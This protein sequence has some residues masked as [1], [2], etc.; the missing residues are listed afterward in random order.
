MNNINKV[1]TKN[2]MISKQQ[3]VSATDNLKKLADVFFAKKELTAIDEIENARNV[4][5]DISQ[6]IKNKISNLQSSPAPVKEKKVVETP[7]EIE[8]KTKP[9][10]EPRKPLVLPSKGIET[11][12]PGKLDA[13]TF[14]QN[15]VRNDNQ[16]RLRNDS[17]SY[18]QNN[19]P[20]Y[21]QSRTWNSSSYQ[22]DNTRQGGTY[23]SQ[24]RTPYQRPYGQKPFGQKPFGPRPYGPRPQF[25]A[26]RTQFGGQRTTPYGNRPFTPRP[27]GPRPF[28]P[29][30]R[31]GNAEVDIDLNALKNTDRTFGNKKKSHNDSQDKKQLSRKAQMRWTGETFEEENDENRVGRRYKVRRKEIEQAPIEAVKIDKA[32]ITTDNLTVKMLSEKIG[33]PVAEIVKKMF[34]LGIM[35]TINSNIDFETAELVSNEFGVKLEKKVA[36]TAE[37]QLQTSLD[38]QIDDDPKNLEKRP[39]IVTVM[40]HVDHGKTSLLD[41]I[42][43]TNVVSGE[44]G[45]ITQK[46]GAYTTKV[47]DRTITFIDTPGHAAFTAM[48]ARGAQ[49]T[50]IAILVVAADDGIMPQTIEAIHHIKDAKVPMIV[51][52]NKIDKPEANVDRVLKE[53]AD[54]GILSEEWGGDT[55]CVPISAKR[56][57]NID[58][59]LEMVLL[60]ADV[61]DLKA[62]PN[63]SAVGTVIESRLDKGK[64]PVA[65]VLVQNGTLKVG[66]T[67]VTGIAFGRIRAMMDENG[68]PVKKATPSTPVQILGLDAVPESGDKLTVVDEKM[69]SQIIN[70][71]KNKIK[72][73]KI[74]SQAGVS[75]DDFFNKVQ[76]GELKNLNIIIKADVQGSVEALKASLVVLKNEEARV[77]CVHSAVGNINE[78]D[79]LL[80]EAAKAII[81]GFNVK[82]E[83]N[84]ENLAKHNKIDIKFYSII[85]ECIDDVTK[86]LK[87]MLAP[88]FADKTVGTVE[89][90]HIFNISSVGTIAGCYVLDGKV[91]RNAK[92]LVMR[93]GKQIAEAQIDSLKVQ[94]NE[95]KEVGKG[96]ECGIKLKN[97]NDIKELDQFVIV[98]SEQVEI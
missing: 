10:D 80:A 67:V 42:R 27:Y 89:V 51:A 16:N 84:A 37:Q 31:L 56:G 40:G 74:K 28:R 73:A 33:A 32:L 66:D 47:K 63:R 6:K 50:D 71:R 44:A 90:R 11:R 18:H 78:S 26:P 91:V 38:A 46:I 94:K 13:A 41:A 48:R 2:T 49:I 25:G 70:E 75:L 5:S 4:I 96:F 14:G 77:V 17:Q 54:Q 69:K 19:R 97:Y 29:L 21:H 35:A 65:S 76:E 43:E 24:N 93:D 83:S 53:L 57:T 60:V 1:E 79:V 20:D 82:A 34:I 23:N 45:G 52:I 64:G 39:P 15:R 98:V 3:K 7:V 12:D 58:K 95:A 30:N 36:E 87:G 8:I 86:A 62:N 85:Y 81:I 92:V 22:H 9:V 55:I 61:Q 72:E 59:L 68:K 88:K